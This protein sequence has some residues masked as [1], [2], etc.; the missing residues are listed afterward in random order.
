M[1]SEEKLATGSYMCWRSEKSGTDR[2]TVRRYVDAAKEARFTREGGGP[3]DAEQLG[4]SSDLATNR[5]LTMHALLY[6]AQR[7]LVVINSFV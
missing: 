2:K 4:E 3:I 6:C 5:T 1:E 7:A